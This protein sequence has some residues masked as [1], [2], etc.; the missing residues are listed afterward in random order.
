[1]RKECAELKKI[2]LQSKDGEV[3]LLTKL[4]VDIVK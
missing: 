4:Q 1:M 2:T 3:N